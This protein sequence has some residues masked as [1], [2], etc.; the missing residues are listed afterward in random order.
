M[1]FVKSKDGNIDT[2]WSNLVLA[3]VGEMLDPDDHVTGIVVSSRPK[4]DRI[5]IWTRIKDD[6]A[7]V[8]AIGHRILETIGLEPHDM[9]TSISLEFNVSD[10]SQ[11]SANG[12][13]H[14]ETVTAGKY[15]RV[16]FIQ[17]SASIST[18]V[19]SGVESPRR[20]SARIGPG[21]SPVGT[22]SPLSPWTSTPSSP[23]TPSSPRQ[24]SS[25][26]PSSRG[27]VGGM[28]GNAFSGPL[29][30]ARRLFST[31]GE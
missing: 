30:S 10:H 11:T 23:L 18:S 20:S 3:L 5:Q 1:L 21:S 13:A 14:K 26:L 28:G 27:R 8:D 24:A 17:R 4:M 7:A 6:V 12:K 31:Q 22:P 9:Q 2:C 16:S 19:P 29:G 25:T 15:M